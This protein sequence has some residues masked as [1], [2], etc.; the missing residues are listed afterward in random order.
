MP[1]LTQ[2]FIDLEIQLPE[3][4]QRF[5]R[6]VEIAGFAIRVTRKILLLHFGIHVTSTCCG[7]AIVGFQIRM[8]FLM[9]CG[10]IS[11]A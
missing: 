1:K 10:W 7:I 3:E 8:V 11:G 6:D 2:Q 9:Y 4:G 5:Y